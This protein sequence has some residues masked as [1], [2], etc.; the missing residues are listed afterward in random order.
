[1]QKLKFL[2]NFSYINNFNYF[3]V[4]IPESNLE[5]LEDLEDLEPIFYNKFFIKKNIFIKKTD[6]GIKYNRKLMSLKRNKNLDLNNLLI[7]C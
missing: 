4:F 5:D 7:N 1:M 3:H 2:Y 6:Y